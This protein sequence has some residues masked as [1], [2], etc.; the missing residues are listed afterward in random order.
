MQ[1]HQSI[2][3]VLSDYFRGLHAGDVE[4]LRS[5]FDPEAVLFAELNGASYHKSLDAYLDG[6]AQR[7]SP[8]EL[9]EAFRMR[10]L[11]LEVLHDMA[12][13]RV[14]VPALGFNF[15]NYLSLLRKGGSWRIVSKV[16][17]DVPAGY[18]E[19]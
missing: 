4:L 10:V 14:H 3:Q 6:V 2:L 12:M 17:D 15:Y 16:F 11:S 5:V 19:S 8:A 1:D 7:S 13:A 18:V 9:N